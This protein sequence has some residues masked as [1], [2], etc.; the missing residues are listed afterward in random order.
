[1]VR[2]V[3]PTLIDA[4]LQIGGTVRSWSALARS[5]GTVYGVQVEGFEASRVVVKLLPYSEEPPWGEEKVTERI[6][7]ER[8]SACPATFALLRAHDLPAPR[9]YHHGRSP[10]GRH[11]VLVIEWLEGS[12]VDLRDASQARAAGELLGRMHTITRA[13][14]GWVEQPAPDATTWRDTVAA[15][16]D[17][18]LAHFEEQG[19]MPDA[20]GPLRY[21]FDHL[22]AAWTEPHAFVLTNFEGIQAMVRHRPD[23]RVEV[24]GLVDIDDVQFTDP[25]FGL[26][27]IIAGA[28]V[29]GGT[30]EQAFWDAYRARGNPGWHDDPVLKLFVLHRLSVWLAVFR[31]D[32]TQPRHR[33]DPTARATEAAIRAL[34]GA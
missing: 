33:D 11:N 13:F 3:G 4:V 20:L 17:E 25:R 30:I 23:G 21:Q 22:L 9:L 34:L 10:D 32:W 24:T 15:S 14:P 18:Q 6:Y 29:G 16:L 31:A 27:G 12:P 26:A 28:A 8:F 1:M 7:G 2:D 19:F 5:W